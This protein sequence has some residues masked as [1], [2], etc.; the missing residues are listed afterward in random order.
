MNG[1]S[2]REGAREKARITSPGLPYR[3]CPPP[4]GS[5]VSKVGRQGD[6]IT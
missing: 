4:D 3:M 2:E 1:I 6:C 5:L